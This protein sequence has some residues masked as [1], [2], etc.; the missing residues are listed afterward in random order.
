MYPL[1][2]S[3]LLSES[4]VNEEETRLVKRI[5]L[6]CNPCELLNTKKHK[7]TSGQNVLL[8][9]KGQSVLL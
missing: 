5:P 2:S 3:T 7:K 4:T 8:Y 9:L 1:K 6:G